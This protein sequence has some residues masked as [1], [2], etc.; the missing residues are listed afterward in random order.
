MPSWLID[1][2]SVQLHRLFK[3]VVTIKKNKLH[4]NLININVDNSKSSMLD[5][6]VILL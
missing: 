3:P 2:K 5:V 6:I 4:F 1:F